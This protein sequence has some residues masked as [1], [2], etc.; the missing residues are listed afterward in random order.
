M[1]LRITKRNLT[2]I[3]IL[4]SCLIFS[5]SIQSRGAFAVENICSNKQSTGQNSAMTNPRAQLEKTQD[6]Q[7]YVDGCGQNL[8]IMHSQLAIQQLS[9]NEIEEL[10]G[11]KANVSAVSVVPELHSNPTSRKKLFLDFDGYEFP[12]NPSDSYWLNNGVFYGLVG[13]GVK[14][15]GLDLDG[16]PN[17]FNALESFYINETWQAVSEAFSVLDIDVTTEF[18]GIEAL[19]RS[20]LLD[21]QFGMSIVISSDARWS[22]KCNCGGVAYQPSINALSPTPGGLNP[23]SPAFSFNRFDINN[24]LNYVSAKDLGGVMSHELG[25]TLGLTHDG[26]TNL[27][28][29]PGHAN[30]LWAPIMGSSWGKGIRQWSRNEYLNGVARWPGNG[31]GE[32]SGGWWPKPNIKDDFM[33]FVCNEIA[34][35]ED[36]FSNTFESAYFIPAP[37][38]EVQGL[39]GNNGDIDFFKFTLNDTKIVSI[40]SNLITPKSPTLDILLKLYDENYNLL[41]SNNPEISMDQ[42]SSVSGMSAAIESTKLNSGNYFLSIQGAGWGNPINSGYSSWG[43]VGRYK[44]KYQLE[45]QNQIPLLITNLE[46][47]LEVGNEIELTTSGGSGFGN[48]TFQANGVKCSI[49]FNRLKATGLTT[50]TVFASK[51]GDENYKSIESK[52]E[53]FRF[54]Y[55]QLD[56]VISNS[57]KFGVVGK[58][59]SLLTSGGSGKGAVRF[60]LTKNNSLC[61]LTGPSL[62]ASEPTSCFVK[63]TK[64]SQG[65]FASKS[66]KEFEFIFK[67]NQNALSI[68]N[69]SNYKIGSEVVLLTSGGSGSGLVTYVVEGNFC[70]LIG[71]KLKASKKTICKVTATKTEDSQFFSVSSRT[72]SISFR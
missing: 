37:E 69:N 57:S 28:Y 59:V 42:F 11:I 52:K 35:R 14:L 29:Y 33:I 56:L 63:A 12:V 60:D 36:D 27:E 3:I 34:F 22:A 62:T 6:S 23:L 2:L 39:V 7:I 20:S 71:N 31:C 24:P 67:F 51:D 53:I 8:A 41:I 13:P 17:E 32:P 65:N 61:K 58:R 44:I 66:S 25:H 55:P 10:S 21:D 5:R 40:Y 19:S 49:Q 30:N 72:L 68:L 47:I 26:T 46:K 18:P 9:I 48:V 43:S 54:L 45:L 64:E 4:V 70:E 15:L 1:N 38:I 16:N 50:C